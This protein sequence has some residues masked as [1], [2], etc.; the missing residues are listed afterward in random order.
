MCTEN[1]SMMIESLGEE[2]SDLKLLDLSNHYIMLGYCEITGTKI[3]VL[4]S[5][6]LYN[7]KNLT[8]LRLSI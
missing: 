7:F 5:P 2:C 8:E 1:W 4:L 3:A 6:T